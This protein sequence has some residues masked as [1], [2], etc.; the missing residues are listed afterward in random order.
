MTEITDTEFSLLRKFLMDASGIDVPETKRYLFLTRLNEFME[1]R[2]CSTFSEL[3]TR[4]TTA[5]DDTLKRSFIQ[6]MTIHESSFFRDTYPFDIMQKNLL[7]ALAETRRTTA[8]LLPPR[9][10]IFSAGCSLGQEPYSIAMVV[11]SWL[12]TYKLFKSENVTILAGDISE[13]ILAKARK[14]SFT[15]MEMGNKIPPDYVK[16]YC[17]KEDH[18]YRVCDDIKNLVR[19]TTLNLSETFLNLGKFDIIFCRNVVIYFPIPLKQKIFKQFYQMLQPD[20]ALF[21]G[22]SESLYKLSNDYNSIDSPYGMYFA[23]IKKL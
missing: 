9:I 10:R 19:F 14:G 4:L 12:E 16:R 1:T 6:E 3:F 13:K 5:R 2:K 15:E 20:G 22:S 18:G 23:P 11:K 17:I 7:S 8:S 21:L